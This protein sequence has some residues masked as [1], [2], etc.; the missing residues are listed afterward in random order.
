MNDLRLAL[1][2]IVPPGSLVHQN[3]A[4]PPV[5][6]LFDAP[7][8]LA[9]LGPAQQFDQL[10][11]REVDAWVGEVAPAFGKLNQSYQNLIVQ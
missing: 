11:T 7:V 2:G 9:A 3:N 5:Q 10:V 8:T 6:C 4:H 1:G